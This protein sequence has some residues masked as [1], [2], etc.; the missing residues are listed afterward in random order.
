MY[1]NAFL[2]VLVCTFLA[3]SNAHAGVV[4]EWNQQAG[5]TLL[6]DTAS[7]NPGMASRTM[8]MM[9]VAIHDAFAATTGKQT[10]YNY[11]SGILASGSSASSAAAA[12]QAAYTV[13]SSIYPDQQSAL[14]SRLASSLSSITDGAAKTA[15]ISLGSQLGASIVTRRSSDGYN[16]STKYTPTPGAGHW[17]PDP[18]NPTQEAWG[19]DWG[20]VQT[21]ALPSNTS[22]MPPAMPSLTSQAY[23]D[24]F[25]E[26]KDLGALNSTTRTADQTEAGI[27]WAY[28]RVGMGTPMRLYNQAIQNISAIQGNSDAQDAE[29][30]AKAFVAAADAG[31]V[32]WN[33]KFEYDLWRPVTGIREAA[34]DGNL[35]TL[36]D[37]DWVP[38]GAPGGSSTDFTP[39]FPTYISGHS[40]FGAAIFTSLAEFYG[41]DDI[42]FSLSSDETG[43]TRSFSNL[44]EAIVE[45]G[46]S[47]VYLGIHWNF[48]DLMGQATGQQI[49]SYVSGNF[50]AVPE[51]SHLALLG[52]VAP[53]LLRGRRRVA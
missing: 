9:N 50:T 32:A 47:R 8:A 30:F 4:I 29:M 51:P 38:L 25:N 14:Q 18:L 34:S 23:A 19:P 43:T 12:A 20:K 10:F 7:Q 52:L 41:T 46:R 40:T 27:F 11:D 36:A 44:T 37:E 21:F 24:A 16:S 39:P 2:R 5:D 42:A 26:V 31:V 45:N 13:L 33:A 15:G 28:D 6:A 1:L 48:D 49:G 35:M 53:A 17:Q 3:I 22:F